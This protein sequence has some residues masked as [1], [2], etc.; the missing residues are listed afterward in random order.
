[1]DPRVNYPSYLALLKDEVEITTEKSLY[2][3]KYRM[4][5]SK[6]NVNRIKT[7]CSSDQRQNKFCSTEEHMHITCVDSGNSRGED[8]STSTIISSAA[9]HNWS[10]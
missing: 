9:L 3:I 4:S 1:M 6:A 7:Q 2:L 5:A 10:N 8:L